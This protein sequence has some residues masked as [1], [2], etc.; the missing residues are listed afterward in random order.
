VAIHYPTGFTLGRDH[1]DALVQAL[2]IKRWHLANAKVVA[3]W[4][5]AREATRG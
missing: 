1:V 4:D 5:A 3:G 2:R